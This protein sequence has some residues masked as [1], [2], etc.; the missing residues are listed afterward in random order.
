MASYRIVCANK[1]H[2]HRHIIDVGTGT[3]AQQWS[4]RWTVEEVRSALQ[5]GHTF[6]TVS[7]STGKRADTCRINGC[8]V[9]T[10]RSDAD[11]VTDNNLDNLGGCLN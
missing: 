9:R 8:T 4:Q 2:P 1:E 10:I 11:A 6:Y 3:T 7:E 5:A